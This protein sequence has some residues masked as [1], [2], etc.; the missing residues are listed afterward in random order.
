MVPA[1][2]ALLATMLGAALGVGV[3]G[4]AL[5]VASIAGVGVVVGLSAVSTSPPAA[6]PVGATTVGGAVSARIDWKPTTA[7]R[8]PNALVPTM[9]DAHKSFFDRLELPLVSGHRSDSGVGSRADVGP[10]SRVAS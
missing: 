6:A 7:R 3:I 9:I 8:I 5:V 1:S 2:T 10:S 4:G